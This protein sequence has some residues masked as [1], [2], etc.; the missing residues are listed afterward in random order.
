MR[1]DP[2]K[3]TDSMYESQNPFDDNPMSLQSNQTMVINEDSD[4]IAR[5]LSKTLPKLT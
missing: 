1:A 4:Q 2:I 5:R 3:M